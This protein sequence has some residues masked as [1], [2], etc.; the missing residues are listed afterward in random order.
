MAPMDPLG[1]W[2]TRAGNSQYLPKPPSPMLAPPTTSRLSQA[3]PLEHN[4]NSSLSFHI[5]FSPL[6]TSTGL[7]GTR[8]PTIAPLYQPPWY[9]LPPQPVF[10]TA[11]SQVLI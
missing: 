6:G 5:S 4:W 10:H 11:A 8:N 1:R 2:L 9:P 7:E 3:S